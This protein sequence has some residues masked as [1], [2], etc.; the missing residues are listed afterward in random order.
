MKLLIVDDSLMIC[1]TIEKTFSSWSFTEIEIVHD[2][3][4]AVEKFKTF[5]PDVVTMDI[6][7]PEMDGLSALKEIISMNENAKVLVISALG[8]HH[9]AIEA[10][11]LGAD[12]FIC[13]PFTPE[14][15]I[16]ALD[17]LLNN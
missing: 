6:T 17:E 3:L 7:M 13:K 16:N 10:L 14:D 5:K 2:G 1:R 9:T 4:L 8:D 12:Q 11:S 15:L